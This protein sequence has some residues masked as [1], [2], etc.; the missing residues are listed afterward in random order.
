MWS[1]L[2]SEELLALD[3]YQ[4]KK[5]CLSEDMATGMFHM[6]QLDLHPCTAALIGL[7]GHG[8]LNEV[9]TRLIHVCELL[10]LNYGNL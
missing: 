7:G 6:Y 10:V 2:P 8:D 9:C 4:R 3:G 5:S 1:F